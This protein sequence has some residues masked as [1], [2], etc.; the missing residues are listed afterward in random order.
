[1]EVLI[2][3]LIKIHLKTQDKNEKDNLYNTS[4]NV[5]YCLQ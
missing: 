1:M 4:N 2:L 5:F 3:G